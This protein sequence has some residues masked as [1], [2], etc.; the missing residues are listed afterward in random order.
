[1]ISSRLQ[2]LSFHRPFCA[3]LTAFCCIHSFA[4]ADWPRWRGPQGTGHIANGQK[5]PP[6]LP[7]DTKTL[8]KTSVGFSL[9][10]PTVSGGKLF[11]MDIQNGKETLHALDAN[12][13]KSWWS[14][15][16]DDTFRDSQ[17]PPGPRFTPLVDGERIY[18]QSCKGELQC[19]NVADG[20]VVWKTNYVKDFGATFTGERGPTLGASRHGYTGSPL[21]DGDKMIIAV[22]GPEAGVVAFEKIS[23][24]VLW[25]SQG[26][27]AAYAGPVNATFGGVPQYVVFMAES[28]MGLQAAD[29]ALLWRYPIKTSFGRH[30]ATP[31]VVGDTVVVSSHQVGL[32]GLKIEKKAEGFEATRAWLS[33]EL[34]INYSS[35]VAVGEW[36]YG[37][38]PNKT[39]FCL[40]GK[41]GQQ[42]WVKDLFFSGVMR[43]D[44]AG[45][46][47]DKDH[48]LALA[49]SGQLA[50][51]AADPKACRDLGRLQVVGDNWCHPAYDNGK[52]WLRDNEEL[53]CVQLSP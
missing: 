16:I 44:Y 46:I 10:S 15:T 33:K 51:V 24:K 42:G 20:K 53:R 5:L 13:G 14:A 19:L 23:G 11:H 2:K 26:E 32:M 17:S 22:G 52:I 48:I 3:L 21:I 38:G 50:L 45:L 6:K 29:G 31:V 43:R 30:A 25:K 12:T 34:A 9:G 1:M 28:V 4:Q 47:A 40:N 41:S 35:P 8:W 36:I 37:V 39:L 27:G 18:A 49:D 7:D